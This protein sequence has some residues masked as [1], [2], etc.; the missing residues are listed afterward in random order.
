MRDRRTAVRQEFVTLGARDGLRHFWRPKNIGVA[1]ILS[2]VHFSFPKKLTTFFSRR[3][4]NTRWNYL[5]N[6]FHRPDLPQF[7]QKFDSCCASGVHSLP[8]GALTTFPC[9]LGPKFFSPRRCTCTQCTPW[10]RL[11]PRTRFH[12]VPVHFSH[13]IRRSKGVFQRNPQSKPGI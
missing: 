1:R 11:C 9:K 2:G 7:P 3:P 8:G 4:Q 12:C 6:L 5:N 10:L 13:W